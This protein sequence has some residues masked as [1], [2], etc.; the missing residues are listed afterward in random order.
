MDFLPPLLTFLAILLPLGRAESD[1]PIVPDA[2]T[3][4]QSDGWQPAPIDLIY[5]PGHVPEQSESYF[6]CLEE[7]A[8]EEE[9]DSTRV[10]DHGIVPLTFLGFESPPTQNL[11][12][13]F[14]PANPHSPL[15][16]HSPILRC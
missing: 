5:C 6:E 12:S 3:T 15:L 10:E 2:S 1:D 14:L 8:L 11:F 16:A 4:A 13:S 9:E 7:T